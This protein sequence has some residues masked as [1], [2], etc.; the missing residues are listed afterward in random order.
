MPT[1]S[2]VGVGAGRELAEHDHLL[3]VELDR[4]HRVRHERIGR[5]VRLGRRV[6]VRGPRPQRAAP[7]QLDRLALLARLRRV[8]RHRDRGRPEVRARLGAAR[9]RAAAGA[10]SSIVNQPSTAGTRVLLTRALPV[11]SASA[12]ASFMMRAISSATVGR[13]SITPATCPLDSTP[14]SR[15]PSTSPA[16]SSIGVFA[17]STT[18]DH[19]RS[20]SL[21]HRE[22]LVAPCRATTCPT[23]S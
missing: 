23:S 4:A 14:A 11:A 10:A 18:C 16:R 2:C 8:A 13:S 19:F 6:V 12:S 22:A 20:A 1:S 17:A 15:R 7:R 5:D 9:A 21:L 3:G